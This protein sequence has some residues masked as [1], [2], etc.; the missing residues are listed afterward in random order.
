MPEPNSD[1]QIPPAT[2]TKRGEPCSGSIVSA[3]R[4]KKREIDRR[5]QRQARERTK[6]RIAYLESLVDS[7]KHPDGDKRSAALMNRLTDTEKERDAL[8]QTLKDIQKTLLSHDGL[9]EK[10]EQTGDVLDSKDTMIKIDEDAEEE[11]NMV[12]R[13]PSKSP[14]QRTSSSSEPSVGSRATHNQPGYETAVEAKDVCV[15]ELPQVSNDA[16][17]CCKDGQTHPDAPTASLWRYAKNTLLEP[18]SG[19]TPIMPEEDFLDVDVPVRVLLEGWEAVDQQMGGLPVSWQILRRIDDSLFAVCPP[20]ERLAVL[21]MMHILLQYH[22]EPTPERRAKLPPWF[23]KR[24]SQTKPHAY[25]INYFV[26]PGLRERFVFEQHKYCSNLFWQLFTNCLTIAWPYDFR[27][28]FAQR[29]DTGGY[30]ISPLFQECISDVSRWTMKQEIFN[31]FPDLRC[32]IPAALTNPRPVSN[33]LQLQMA[34][35]QA[36]AQAQAQA[37]G[38]IGRGVGSGKSAY[39]ATAQMRPQMAMGPM[40]QSQNGLQ[41][42][43]DQSSSFMPPYVDATI[44]PWI[45]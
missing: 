34:Q 12:S 44:S 18:H 43:M 21:R 22:R 41:P 10:M 32:D 11:A 23:L 25:A 3:R 39:P 16:C 17:E 40:W 28:C 30:E 8:A 20:T 42:F 13:V 2:T 6:S 19:N 14:K 7:L 4:L 27:D 26:W 9:D 31:T 24:P 33:M 36:Q 1:I 38:L 35:V 29:M 15:K 5:C 45:S 37:R